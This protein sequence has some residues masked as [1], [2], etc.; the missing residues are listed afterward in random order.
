M[1]SPLMLIVAH[2][3]FL[4]QF[5]ATCEAHGVLVLTGIIH[6]LQGCVSDSVVPW[7]NSGSMILPGAGLNPPIERGHSEQKPDLSCAV[8]VLLVSIML[9]DKSAFRCQLRIFATAAI[10]CHGKV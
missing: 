4:C 1:G 9:T 6:G 2:G 3:V 7:K 5:L 8:P 10:A